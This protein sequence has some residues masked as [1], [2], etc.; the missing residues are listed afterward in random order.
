MHLIMLRP[1][2]CMH[3]IFN[4]FQQVIWKNARLY[5]WI[6]CFYWNS[7]RKKENLE[8]L[9]VGDLTPGN[10]NSDNLVLLPELIMDIFHWDKLALKL[11]ALKTLYYGQ[12]TLSPPM[13][14]HSFVT[15]FIHDKLE[16]ICSFQ[17][18]G[19]IVFLS[20]GFSSLNWI[21]KS[22]SWLVFCTIECI[23]L[24]ETFI[25]GLHSDSSLKVCLT[26]AA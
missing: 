26:L 24:C 18:Q 7:S 5:S 6:V 16:L 13:Q 11:S 8:G 12:F 3:S 1:V 2:A 20:M 14:H 10:G 15:P 22:R 25:I 17:S 21:K 4:F 9:I 23:W 19:I